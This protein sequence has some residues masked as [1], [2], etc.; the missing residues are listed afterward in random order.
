M[1]LRKLPL[2]ARVY[3]TLVIAAGA[4]TAVAFVPRTAPEPGTFFFLLLAACLTSAWKINLPIPLASGSTLS[5]SYAANLMALLLLGPRA[6]LVIAAAGAWTQCT[7]N[8]KQRYP[9]YRTVFSIAA[10]ILTMA[11]TGWAYQAFGGAPGPLVLASLVKPLVAAIATYFCVNTGLVAVGIG[12]STRRPAGRVWREDFLW[13][14][15]SFMVAGTAGALA[16]L[17]I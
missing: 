2:A 13:S 16:A 7:V 14:A 17:V 15:A 1:T 9:L 11:A 5:V 8:V 10:E 6:A 12:L 3:V 4:A